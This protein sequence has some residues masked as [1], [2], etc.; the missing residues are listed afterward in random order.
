MARFSKRS[1]AAAA[2]LVM[3]PTAVTVTPQVARADGEVLCDGLLT[4]SWEWTD[5]Y[6]EPDV[7]SRDVPYKPQ[8][9]PSARQLNRFGRERPTET[10]TAQPDVGGIQVAAPGVLW[11][12][13]GED[14]GGNEFSAR[15]AEGRAVVTRAP[16]FAEQFA[17]NEDGSFT[18]VP[19]DR[20]FGADSFEYMWVV[21]TH[22]SNPATVQI[23]NAL[24]PYP[25]PDRFSI[26]GDQ[27]LDV[28]QRPCGFYCGVLDNEQNMR[29]EV[30]FLWMDGFPP[31]L[32]DPH[33]VTD[34]YV[35]GTR[36]PGS[37][38][39]IKTTLGTLSDLRPDGTFVYTP[40][41][42]ARGTDK[43]EYKLSDA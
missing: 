37:W 25:I 33:T 26:F 21:A 36:Y 27:Q 43:F 24:K 8:L 10:D 1:I 7:Y 12:D 20:Y 29:K 14:F 32:D 41:P 30:P 6:A 17:L 34:W 22:C 5:S 39:T 3:L 9:L 15:G 35:K 2:L 40:D 16:R 13:Y 11:N 18:Y 4:S 38:P 31:V 23:T 28:K 19:I 42:G